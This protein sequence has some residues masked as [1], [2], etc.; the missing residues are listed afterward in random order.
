MVRIIPALIILTAGSV[1]LAQ[2]APAPQ[3]APATV[4]KSV[5]HVVQHSHVTTTTN[6]HAPAGHQVHSSVKKATVKTP[7]GT[8]THTV[9]HTTSSTTP[10]Q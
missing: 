4:H 9:T 7:A 10:P 3:P 8:Q 2:T 5:R 6:S 1:A